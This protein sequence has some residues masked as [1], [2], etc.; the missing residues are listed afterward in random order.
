M[1]VV[2]SEKRKKEPPI[3]DPNSLSSIR[4]E[5]I[6][7]ARLV[8]LCLGLSTGLFLSFLDS[9]IVA[10]SLFTIGT[11]FDDLQRVNWVALAYT[12]SY[13]GCAVFLARISDVIGRRDAFLISYV[14]F[15]GFSLGCGFAQN[16]QQLIAF[17]AIQG[18]GGSGLYSITMIIL[19]EISPPRLLQALAG[20]IGIIITISSVL[21]PVLGGILTNY[22]SWRWIFFINGPIG[23]ASFLLFLITWPNPRYLPNNLEKRSWRELDYFGSSL[24]V[25]AAVLIVFPFQNA[26]NATD[27]WH[28][29]IF[30]APLTI[31]LV[32]FLGVFAWS[33]FVDRR[34]GDNVAAALP[35]NLLRDRVYASAVLNTLFLGF[36][37]ILVIY[38]FPLRCQVVN[39][40]DAL[41][42]G[43]MLLPMLGSSAIGSVISGKVNGKEDRSCETLIV[44]TSFMILGCGL[45][46]TVSGSVS[47][48]AKALGF[49][50]FVGLGFGL[51]V[52]TTTMLAALRSSIRD[53]ASA[54]GIVAQVRVF[55]GSL[56]I[57]AS[58]AILG[59]SLRAQV[60]GSV[61]SQQIS[62]VEGGGGDNL[63]PNDLAAIRR[64]YAEA[65]RED[66]R[67][68]TIISGIALIW[69]LGTY[70]RK[71][72]NR[73]QQREQRVRDEAERRKTVAAAESPQRDSE[74]NHS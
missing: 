20:I 35:M 73:S 58:S 56:G 15:I 5:E 45:L 67:V 24:F 3:L 46:T 72:L 60:G 28:E 47:L 18:L 74:L 16:L 9:S 27:Q 11:E 38:V 41:V 62:S 66:M 12:L 10:T 61:T 30:W 32:A 43:V 4:H 71:R 25:A 26:S 39:G 59:M 34:W 69:A 33:L 21:G 6:P 48:E 53:H 36:P 19:P 17:R 37:Y 68:C 70:S 65:F 49:L 7:T 63:A 40:K 1:T 57:A 51:S 23:A 54:Q 29:A 64:A 44:A 13:L 8:L 52:S 2:S 50:V 42:A 14:I 31:G 55:G 22:V